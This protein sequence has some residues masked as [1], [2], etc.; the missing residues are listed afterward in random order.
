MEAKSENSVMTNT[1]VDEISSHEMKPQC[2]RGTDE[3]A[4]ATETTFKED[5]SLVDVGMK[6]DDDVD[7][8]SDEIEDGELVSSSS[9]ESELEPEETVQEKGKSY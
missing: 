2:L 7:D 3:E 9:S 1:K 4:V 5:V 8:E 6:N